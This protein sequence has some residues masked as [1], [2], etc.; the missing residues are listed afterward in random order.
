MIDR[1]LDEPQH[2]EQQHAYRMRGRKCRTLA[3]ANYH[4]HTYMC[5]YVL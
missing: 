5:M 2:Q 3:G 1:V 4:L